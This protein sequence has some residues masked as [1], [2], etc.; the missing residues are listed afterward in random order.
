M[1][2]AAIFALWTTVHRADLSGKIATSA[3]LTG[4]VVIAALSVHGK[5][6]LINFGRSMMEE[7]YATVKAYPSQC[8]FPYDPLAHLL[9]GD[10]F[11]PKHRYHL[12]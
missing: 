2:L 11:R 12:Y 8:Y 6:K 10:R 9:A 1:N 5:L 4:A 3:G 7:S